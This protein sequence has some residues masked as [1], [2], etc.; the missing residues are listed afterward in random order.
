MEFDDEV[1]PR[2]PKCHS[3]KLLKKVQGDYVCMKCGASID[4]PEVSADALA[5]FFD[6]KLKQLLPKV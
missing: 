4:I 3:V 1:R 2:C 5:E 6:S